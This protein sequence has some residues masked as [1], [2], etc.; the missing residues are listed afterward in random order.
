MK[1]RERAAARRGCLQPFRRPGHRIR[2]RPARRKH[3]PEL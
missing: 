1:T 2:R 3:R